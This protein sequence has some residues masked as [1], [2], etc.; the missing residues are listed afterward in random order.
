[1]RRCEGGAFCRAGVKLVLDGRGVIWHDIFIL[2]ASKERQCAFLQKGV[3]TMKYRSIIETLRAFSALSNIQECARKKSVPP[4]PVEGIYEYF[5][6]LYGDR[7]Y[8]PKGELGYDGRIV[9]YFDTLAR[10]D[11]YECRGVVKQKIC[12]ML[13]IPV[14]ISANG[15]DVPNY[16]EPRREYSTGDEAILRAAIRRGMVTLVANIENGLVDECFAQLAEGEIK[17]FYA[18]VCDELYAAEL[19]VNQLV[20][21]AESK[22]IMVKVVD[23]KYFEAA[24][25]CLSQ[26]R[27]YLRECG[28]DDLPKVPDLAGLMQCHWSMLVMLG[29][30]GVLSPT[31]EKK[32]LGE[33]MGSVSYCGSSYG[34]VR[35]LRSIRE[36][37][38]EFMLDSV[39]TNNNFVDLIVAK[40]EEAEEKG[41]A[42]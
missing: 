21:L 19:G 24:D 22:N 3:N 11:D 6:R 33:F 31:V 10:F 41:V 32:I 17:E 39:F 5:A 13:A 35:L 1:M 4:E 23:D 8:V 18:E 36:A 20:W 9:E 29:F 34:I 27:D 37:M 7:C 2:A 26:N 42:C 40:L 30:G 15:D 28:I 25:E 12:E 16:L 14:T 38:L